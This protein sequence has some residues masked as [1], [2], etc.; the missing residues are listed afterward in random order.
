MPNEDDVEDDLL[1][2]ISKAD[3]EEIIA[4]QQPLMESTLAT[5][6]ATYFAGYIYKYIKKSHRSITKVELNDC[7]ICKNLIREPDPEMHSI[8]LRKDYGVLDNNL[9]LIYCTEEFIYYLMKL[10]KIHLYFFKQSLSNVNYLKS[11]VANVLEYEESNIFCCVEFKEKVIER[12]FLCR[13]LNDIEKKNHELNKIDYTQKF[14]K[15]KHA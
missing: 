1:F 14:I 15:L 8:V 9:R 6:A 2:F 10:E 11:L 3:Y 7:E 12:Y 5:D 4:A 13:L